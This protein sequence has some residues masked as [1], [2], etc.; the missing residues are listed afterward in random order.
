MGNRKIMTLLLIGI[1]YSFS[2]A[3]KIAFIIDSG[4]MLVKKQAD[5]TW[6]TLENTGSVESGDSLLAGET[7][8]AECTLLKSVKLVLK[9]SCTFVMSASEK[10]VVI[11]LIRGQIFLNREADSAEVIVEIKANGCIFT[12]IGTAAA[13]KITKN[14]DP[15]VAVLKGKIRMTKSDGGAVDVDAGNY[16]T[17]NA[18]ANSF[19]PVK[20]LP[21]KAIES[22]ESWS[23]VKHGESAASASEEVK[24]EEPSQT[25]G[26]AQADVAQAPAGENPAQEAVVETPLVSPEPV[27]AEKPETTPPAQPAEQPA[28]EPEKKEEKKE[29]AGAQPATP[30]GEGKP[31]E[32]VAEKR[33]PDKGEKEPDKPQW[34]IS[35]GM[36]T[37][38][39]E[40]WTRIAFG[41]DVPIWRFGVFFDLELFLDAQGDF[42]N[43]GWDFSGGREAGFSLLRK[44]R[45]IR[46]NHPGDPLYFKLGGLD[47][48]TFGYGFIVDRLTNMLHYPGEKLFGLQFDLNDLGPIGI[49]L[50]TLVADFKD[51]AND[52]GILAGRLAFKPFKKTGKPIIGGLSIAATVAS[53]INQYAPAREWDY[54]LDGDR[55]DK[56]EDDVTDSTYLYT[57]YKDYPYYDNLIQDHKNLDDYDTKV[58]HK[59]EWAK[60]AEDKVIV[61]GGD[62]IIPII[63]SELLNLDLYGQ[64]GVMV[65]DENEDKFYKGWGIGAPG[66]G[67]KVGPVWARL[68]YRHIE[69]Y[70]EPAYFG[71][72]YLDERIMRT[73]EVHVKED[74]LP[75]VD[76]NGVFGLCGFNIKNIVILSGSYQ[77]L[78]GDPDVLD[79]RAEA[80]VDVG[81]VLLERIPKINKVNGFF[82]Q[83]HIDKTEKRPFFYQSPYTYW[84]YRLGV[85]VLAGASVIWETRYGWKWNRDRT[86]LLDD[87]T[88][89]I[90]AA[91]T[92]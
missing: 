9:D 74:A 23:G 3:G 82:Y 8:K 87:K 27:V 15:S 24:V 42:S 66:V 14:G 53:D 67:L 88:V 68:E 60:S 72:Y 18:A 50:Q 43:R 35:A 63:S 31:D 29:P 21:P 56:D 47:N 61:L 36:V 11:H 38:D 73:P 44:I 5:I 10:K 92:F 37:V 59:D 40:Q 57:T 86:K 54:T 58:E 2:F 75:A 1:L 22:L 83:T 90:Q 52:G 71:P 17:Y 39:N 12:P 81:E 49:S 46:F 69:E 89:T 16:C 91:L 80:E 65:D 77:R 13:V 48:V 62:I 25:E 26:P 6:T 78:V 19:T 33:K 70:F 79:Q 32:K 34:E 64:A 76:L 84:G 51:F 41:V 55:R 85:E 7:G 20:Q 45:Y 30:A 28:E 4:E